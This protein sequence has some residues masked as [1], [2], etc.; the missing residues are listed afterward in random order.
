MLLQTLAR[1]RSLLVSLSGLFDKKTKGKIFKISRSHLKSL[2]KLYL[3][4]IAAKRNAC[5]LD[6]GEPKKNK[7]A[8]A[9]QFAGIFGTSVMQIIPQVPSWNYFTRCII[10]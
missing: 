4:D 5:T 10:S 2:N 7:H 1:W 3:T 6:F 9:M 8:E